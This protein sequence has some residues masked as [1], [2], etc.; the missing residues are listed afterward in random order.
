MEKTPTWEELIFYHTKTDKLQSRTC[1]IYNRKVQV[2]EN[3]TSVCPCGRLVR[4][5]S[6]NGI[7]LQSEAAND[8]K[9]QWTPPETFESVSSTAVPPT[10]FGRLKP[11]DCKFI[12]LDDQTRMGCVYD[13]LLEDCGR[14]KPALILSAY[15]GAK[16]FTMTEK[17]EK[18]IIR[19]IIDA[20]TT[21]GKYNN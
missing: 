3:D 21:A 8:R 19:G 4:C 5:H 16:Y 17:L 2:P 6:F 1:K 13:L 10:V 7:S 12:R 11:T 14:K 9:P 20:A 18:E 15:G